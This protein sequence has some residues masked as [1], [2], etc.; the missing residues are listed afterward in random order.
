MST[1]TN[2]PYTTSVCMRTKCACLLLWAHCETG[3]PVPDALFSV[4][5]TLI[6][7]VRCGMWETVIKP[8][9]H[10]WPKGWQR[11]QVPL[12]TSASPGRLRQRPARDAATRAAASRRATRPPTARAASGCQKAAAANPSPSRPWD[13]PRSATTGGT[14]A[15]SAVH[16]SRPS[17]TPI[18]GGRHGKWNGGWGGATCVALPPPG[19]SFAAETSA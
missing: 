15:A 3:P 5:A 11:R 14:V 7:A 2:G 19:L 13:P 16:A 18:A 10:P 8:S 1:T 6:P 9:P 4:L 12:P 17:P